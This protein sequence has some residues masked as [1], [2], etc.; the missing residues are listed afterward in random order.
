MSR[1]QYLGA[2]AASIMSKTGEYATMQSAGGA[3]PSAPSGAIALPIPN[4][5]Q[6]DAFN[7]NREGWEGFTNTLYD[8]A[9]YAAAGATQLNFFNTPV[10]Q[11]T[12]FGGGAKT[13][14]DTNMTLAGQM[15]ANQEFLIQ[16]IEIL[17]D[18]TTPTVAAG[19]PAVFGAQLV[20]TI[21]ND[22]YIFWRAGNLNLV[23][24]S[25][26][27]CQE[28]P[29]MKFPPKAF[30]E[31]HAALADV[32]TAGASFQSRIAFAT[33]RG[34]PYLLKAPLRLVSNQNFGVSLNWPEGLQAITNPARITVTLDGVFYRRSQ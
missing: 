6:L 21:I 17:F 3:L 34:R 7:V 16:S 4:R 33:S 9:S 15:P 19:M 8:S 18:P 23:I 10:G 14:S 29:L 12:G 28:A 5:S 25:K 32:T 22:A 26:S 11:G 30:F 27:Y 31:L 2:V 13:L 20:A 1:N 24:G